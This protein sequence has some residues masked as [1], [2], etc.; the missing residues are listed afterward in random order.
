MSIL[1][2]GTC[3]S[4][5]FQVHSE[6]SAD[7]KTLMATHLNTSHGQDYLFTANIPIKD[8]EDFTVVRIRDSE[9][10]ATLL[11]V[12][13]NRGYWKAIR[14]HPDAKPCRKECLGNNIIHKDSGTRL[15]DICEHN[16]Q[17]QTTLFSGLS[18]G[19]FKPF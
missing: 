17:L 1:Y 16:P 11:S 8:F 19:E 14:T 4:C 18:S 2:V 12:F 5:G 7:F 3:K 13:H 15:C 9:T 10:I 6:D